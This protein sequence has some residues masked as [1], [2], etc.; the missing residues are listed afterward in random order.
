M[1]RRFAALGAAALASAAVAVPALA[2]GGG[3]TTTVTFTELSNDATFRFVDN[4]PKTKLT[5]N[6][7]KKTSAGDFFVLTTPLADATK[8]RVGEVR[9]QCVAGRTAKS[10]GKAA[11]FC[12]GVMAFKDGSSLTLAVADIGT[13]K[14][15]KAAVT[16]GTGTYAG[17]R[18]S[19]TSTTQSNGNSEDV[20]TL[21]D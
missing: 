8:K 13:A 21:I 14:V 11:F 5:K 20:I 19:L 3:T 4:A 9:L 16:G 15:T 10:F 7:P 17:A 1:T 12:N 18:G 6:G 2:Q